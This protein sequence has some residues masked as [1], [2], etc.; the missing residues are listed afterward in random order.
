MEYSMLLARII[1][2]V[3]LVLILSYILN[4]GR[5]DKMV[6]DMVKSPMVLYSA[7]VLGLIGG[8]ILVT[9]HNVWVYEWTVLVTVIGWVMVVK[10]VFLLFLGEIMMDI[11]KWVM[12]KKALLMVGMLIGLVFG[13]YLTYM[14]YFS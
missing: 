3:Y 6:H 13:V 12:K 8:M 14:G 7:A 9:T 10:S 5:Y 2:P 1:G 11:T 4:P